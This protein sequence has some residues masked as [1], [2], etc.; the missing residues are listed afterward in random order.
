MPPPIMIS[1]PGATLPYLT[2]TLLSHHPPTSLILKTDI[3]NTALSTYNSTTRSFLYNTTGSDLKTFHRLPTD[4]YRF[5]VYT[6]F[7]GDDGTCQVVQGK[8]NGVDVI[9]GMSCDTGGNGRQYLPLATLLPCYFGLIGGSYGGN[10]QGLVLPWRVVKATSSK[11]AARKMC[12][13]TS[14]ITD[15]ILARVTNEEKTIIPFIHV[16]LIITMN[17]GG[18]S[19]T[20]MAERVASVVKEN[21]CVKG[22]VVVVN[23]REWD[24]TLVQ[25]VE[26]KVGFLRDNG[27]NLITLV[28]ECLDDL[29][30]VY[31]SDVLRE[32]VTQVDAGTVVRK[33]AEEGKAVSVARASGRTGGEEKRAKTAAA[34]KWSVVLEDLADVMYANKHSVLGGA[35]GETSVVGKREHSYAYVHHLTKCS[36]LLGIVLLHDYNLEQVLKMTKEA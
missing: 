25:V 28:V 5:I 16:P 3:I 15:A 12:S 30:A 36:E 20:F 9:K 17:D 21:A 22:A 26:E 2:P 35:V 34:P 19:S 4:T 33:I 10:N 29:L 18:V 8:E 24:S 11:N 7:E 6:Q 31:N 1:C 23:G 13:K 14:E 27:V 32:G